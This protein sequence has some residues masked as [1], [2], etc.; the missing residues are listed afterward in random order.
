[1]PT[2]YPPSGKAESGEATHAE[3]L[4]AST[5]DA[6]GNASRWSR[7]ASTLLTARWLIRMAVLLILGLYVRT[8]G[9][10]PVYDDNVVTPWTSLRDVPRFFAH[11]IFGFD[12]SAHSVYY[13]PVAETWGLLV[14]LST[15]G[16][17]GWLHLSAIFL[18]V[19]VVILAYVFGRHLSGDERMALLTAVLFGLHPSKVES[20]A[21]IGS[22]NVDGLGAVFFFASLIM[23]FKWRENQALRWLAASVSLFAAAMFTK[24]TMVFVPILIAAYLWLTLPSAGRISRILRT[25]LPYG[26]VW[27]VYMAI[28]H[29]IIKPAS[30]AAEYIH[31][32]FT[33]S[34]LWTAP[35]AIWWYI[36][37]LVFPWGL[38]VEYESTVLEHPTL[39]GF[40]LPAVSLLLLLAATWWLW[41]RQR[42]KVAAF[43]IF[44]FALTLAP[45]VIVAPMVLQHDRYLY[46][47]SFAFCALI[48]WAILHLGSLQNTTRL[49]VALCVV[50]FWSGLT[51]HEMG[52]WDCDMT[53]WSRVLQISPSQQKAQV[54]LA[55]LYQEAGDPA[56]GLDMLNEA[57]RYRPNAPNLWLARANFLRGNK[58][59]DG[60]RAGYLKVM[61]VD[62]TCGGTGG[63]S[64]CSL[65][66][67]CRFRLSVGPDG[68]LREQ[69]RGSRAL[70]ASGAQPE[71]QRCG[72]SQRALPVPASRGPRRGSEGRECAGTA[73]AAGATG[74]AAS[75][76][77]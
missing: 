39:F 36:G 58:Q 5:L 40:V 53:L 59:L 45:A 18:H 37:H 4:V 62:R 63:S 48:A 74:G 19:V 16:A 65:A 51:W 7:V 35:Y 9:F 6:S 1:M 22:S 70:R 72:V 14:S 56:K 44:W 67:A 25:L 43:L 64:R 77:E 15:G 68:Y 3:V 20:V 24:E 31:P 10:A 8:I 28:R 76:R 34:N 38:A 29:Q 55:S 11:D 52:F 75:V 73:S 60:A 33:L 26:A 47:A 61:R 54:Q 57:L 30:A 12:G 23:F 13:R 49:V 42:S 69:L 27:I 46:I 21:W 2:R 50:A 17:P 32:T 71:P 41:R 66:S